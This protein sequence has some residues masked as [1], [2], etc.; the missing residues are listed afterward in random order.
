MRLLLAVRS[1]GEGG[2]YCF[3]P[4]GLPYDEGRIVLFFD[5]FDPRFR[6]PL[7]LPHLVARLRPVV[8]RL[9]SSFVFAIFISILFHLV[10][11][12]F[13]PSHLYLPCLTCN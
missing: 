8:F 10:V 2:V 4:R 13:S 5:G 1:D 11:S 3:L 12:S 7:E 9:L 6:L